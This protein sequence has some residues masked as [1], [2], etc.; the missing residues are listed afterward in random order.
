MSQN[1][2]MYAQNVYFPDVFKGC[3]HDCVYCKPS[4]QRQAKR[5]KQRCLKCY[6]FEPHDHFERLKG[7]TPATKPGE[8]IF[9][10]KGADLCFASTKEWEQ[11]VHF[12]ESNPQTTFLIQTKEPYCFNR[13]ENPWTINEGC[14]PRDF[15]PNVILGMTLETDRYNFS[16]EASQYK[17][18]P[19]ISKAEYP[20]ERIHA[21]QS[22]RHKRKEITIEPILQFTEQFEWQIRKLKPEFVYIGYDTK[23]CK[24]PEPTLAETQGLIEKL[25]ASGI[26]VRLKTI[27]KAWYETEQ[28]TLNLSLTQHQSNENNSTTE[29]K[30]ND[31]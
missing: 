7:R 15:P 20:I 2:T 10:P 21:F 18:Y 27:R 22:F 13:Y 8:F 4:F 25:K 19:Q 16:V 29:A 28:T 23:G 14:E 3:K 30:S 12:I 31:A 6:T 24:L 26:D 11:I 9:F 17:S 5:Q 1:Q